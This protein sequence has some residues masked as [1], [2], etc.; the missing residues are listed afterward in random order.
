M[1][2]LISS[3]GTITLTTMTVLVSLSFSS[4]ASAQSAVDNIRPVGQI[5]LAGQPCEGQPIG[6]ASATSASSAPAPAPAAAPQASQPADPAPEPEP[7]AAEPMVAAND[8]FDPAAKY[9]MSCMACHA[10]GAAGAPKIGDTA[11]WDEKMAKGWDAVMNNVMNGI[12][13]MPAKGMCMDCNQEQLRSI[14]EYMI[15]Q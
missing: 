14:V 4:T 12:N 5:C 10:T 2:K 8:G 7:A 3:L 15:E 9:Q 1:N 13:A 11:A 6:G